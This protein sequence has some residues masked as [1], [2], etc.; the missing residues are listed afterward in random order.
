MAQK[1]CDFT[2]EL[3]GD[4]GE[5]RMV[6]LGEK[7]D[8]GYFVEVIEFEIDA[9]GVG[10]RITIPISDESDRASLMRGLGKLHNSLKNHR[11]KQNLVDSDDDNEKE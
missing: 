9:N 8:D 4:D 2:T 5:V 3:A 11:G 6:H 1:L 7:Q 10:A